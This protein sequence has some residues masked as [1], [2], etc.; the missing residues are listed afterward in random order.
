MSKVFLF[1][2]IDYI[3][4]GENIKTDFTSDYVN[5]NIIPSDIIHYIDPVKFEKELQT[6]SLDKVNHTIS[7]LYEKRD[8]IIKEKRYLYETSEHKDKS[9]EEKKDI[10]DN[11]NFYNRN[12]ISAIDNRLELL[13]KRKS[14]LEP[15]SNVINFQ[16]FK[17]MI[18]SELIKELESYKSGNYKF[19]NGT[20]LCTNIEVLKKFVE[21]SLHKQFPRLLGE[22]LTTNEFENNKLEHDFIC[23]KVYDA[24]MTNNTACLEVFIAHGIDLK[25]IKKKGYEENILHLAV[26]KG[27]IILAKLALESGFSIDSEVDTVETPF[28][29]AIKKND[30]EM[31]N[32][33]VKQGALDG[34]RFEKYNKSGNILYF[35]VVTNKLNIIEL[36]EKNGII[37]N[38]D[39]KQYTNDR[40]ILRF[41]FAKNGKN[42]NFEENQKNKE[43]EDAYKFIENDD[44]ESLIKLEKSGKNLSEMYYDGEPGICIALKFNNWKIVEYFANN[45]D[46][47]NL[48]DSINGRNALHYV[49]MESD[50][51]KIY[52]FSND[53]DYKLEY[54]MK[55]DS[56][57]IIDLLLEKG[58]DVNAQDFDGNT[59]LNLAVGRFVSDSDL[60]VPLKLLEKGANPNILNLKKQNTLFF[61][62]YTMLANLT[63]GL[64]SKKP[65]INQ[66]DVNEFTPLTYYLMKSPYKNNVEIWLE[67]GADVNVTNSN[68]QTPLHLA[69]LVNNENA[70]WRLLEH[71]ADL[72][73]QDIDGN[74]SLHYVAKYA[75]TKKMLEVIYRYKKSF[76]FTIKNNDGKTPLEIGNPNCFCQSPL[77]DKLINTKKAVKDE[78]NTN[79]VKSV[80]SD[81]KTLKI[82]EGNLK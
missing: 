21:L 64:F 4:K 9:R 72:N 43:W 37:V 23:S 56:G 36:L 13:S 33:L 59:A 77:F 14:I 38:E 7:H 75:P 51:S 32:F 55:K 61:L 70:V 39:L 12:N 2:C 79:N 73:K 63:R 6:A 16:N 31:I 24:I 66:K 60:S 80:N 26:K 8:K 11:N 62:Q 10:V 20:K 81:S 53:R 50:R 22:T 54:N 34:N 1:K 41:I 15:S 27:N 42:I 57:K 29:L 25:A 3:Y 58:F 19:Y 48:I 35:S 78:N 49:V 67:N 71:G 28:E 17:N 69:I 74:T 52:Q 82:P 44:L 5:N 18:E 45:Y 76:D 46:C 68:K 30:Y 47:R 40:K 65:N